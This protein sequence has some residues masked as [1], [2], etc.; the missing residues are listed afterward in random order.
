VA[1]ETKGKASWLGYFTR[2]KKDFQRNIGLRCAQSE[3]VAAGP[4]KVGP[5]GRRFH[6]PVCDF[7]WLAVGPT[8]FPLASSRQH[9]SQAFHGRLRATA[10][11]APLF[12]KA[13]FV[14]DGS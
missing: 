7:F 14:R 12:L 13:C 9:N 6:T 3:F 2:M 4:D 5:T 11:A 10:A 1:K 8:S